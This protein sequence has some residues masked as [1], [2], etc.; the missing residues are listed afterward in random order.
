MLVKILIAP[1]FDNPQ[2]N[3]FNTGTSGNSGEPVNRFGSFPGTSPQK[4]IKHNCHWHLVSK[5]F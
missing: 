3:I 4:P 1:Q 5:I 2:F